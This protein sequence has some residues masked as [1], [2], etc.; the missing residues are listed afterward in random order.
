LT[1]GKTVREKIYAPIDKEFE[2]AGSQQIEPMETI[3][4]QH[5]VNSGHSW[6]SVGKSWNA[7][8]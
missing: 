5:L 1:F 8:G 2:V 4:A 6:P 7:D 3:I